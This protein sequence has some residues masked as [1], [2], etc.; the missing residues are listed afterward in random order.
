MAGQSNNV[1]VKV[2][3]LQGPAL[4]PYLFL[5]LIYILTEKVIKDAPESIT[6]ADDIVLC[7]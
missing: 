3:L 1:G 7:G 5:I 4:R 2:V 6:F